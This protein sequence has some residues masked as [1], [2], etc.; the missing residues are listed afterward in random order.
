MLLFAIC[1]LLASV[2]GAAPDALVPPNRPIA[3]LTQKEWSVRWWQWAASFDD[4]AKSPVADT[5][6]AQCAAKQEGGVWFLAG[7]YETRRTNRTCAIPDGKYIFFPLVNYVVFPRGARAGE[8]GQYV[9]EA[10]MV[11]ASPSAL[12]LEL[13]G[14][15]YDKLEQHRQAPAGCFDLGARSSPPVRI[16]PAAANGYYVMLR[17]LDPGTHMLNFGGI[18]PSISQAVTYTL[19]VE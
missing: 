5:N 18:L 12:V 19:K 11:T 16:H 9:A 15:R 1:T 2:A 3:G 8:C 13:N 4:Y 7:T 10:A 14:T 6:G 17:P